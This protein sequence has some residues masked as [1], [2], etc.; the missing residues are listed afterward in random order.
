MIEGLMLKALTVHPDDRGWVMEILRK[1]DDLFVGFG[2][3]YV[4]AVYPGVV[5]AWHTHRKQYDQFCCLAGMVKVAFYDA[6]DDSPTAGELFELCVGEQKP[7]LVRVPPGVFHGW[8][9]ISLGTALVANV[10]SE[11]YDRED[12]DVERLPAHGGPIP[13]DW[14]TIDR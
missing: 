3:V 11:P 1:D 8:K 7:T 13:Y 5:K 9:C 2:Q 14:A 6:R 4:S 12:P 10:A